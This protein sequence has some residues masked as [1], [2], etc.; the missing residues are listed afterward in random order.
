MRIGFT[1]LLA[2]T[3]CAFTSISSSSS[4]GRSTSIRPSTELYLYDKVEE[5][6][7]E[8]QRI[9]AADPTSQECRVAWDIVEE[10]E[11]ADSHQG[12]FVS[13]A[14]RI[15]EGPDAAALM[16]SFDILLSKIDGKMDQLTA[17]T[18]KFAEL[19]SR[20]PS[21]A[22]LHQR[23]YEMKNAIAHARASSNQQY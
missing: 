20:D 19:G 18:E 11:A 14:T 22:E 1:F 13:T 15:D 6:I 4:T 16:G 5:A 21:M 8:A 12:R 7:A 3:A 23:A 10:L 2:S 9:C 17:T